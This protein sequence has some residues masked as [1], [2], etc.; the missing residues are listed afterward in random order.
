MPRRFCTPLLAGALLLGACSD[1]TVPDY[2]NPSIE[3]LESNPSRAGVNAA[4]TG[5]LV[6][7]RNNIASP[8]AYVSLLGILGRES[9]NFDP[10]EPRFIT[11]MLAGPMSPSGA[12]GGNIWAVRYRNIRNA[13]VVLGAVEKVPA[14]SEA[15]KEA[16]RGFAKTMQALDFLLVINA[17][18]ANGAP[19]D[20]N[21]PLNELNQNPPKIEPKSAVLQHVAALLDAADTHLQRGGGAFPF[22]ISSGF[23]GFD[24]PTRFRQF[25]RALR[26]R[27]ATYMGAYPQALTA[28]QG[29]FLSTS[30]PLALGAYYTFAPGSGETP[31][32]L[33]A[34][35]IR[36]HPSIRTD[37]ERR[38]DGTAD[39]R[40]VEKTEDVAPR[41]QAGLSSDL[42]F[43]L[44]ASN[45]APVAIIRNEE[46]ILLRAEA[47]WFT[48]DRRGA[49]EDLNLIRQS[50]GGLQAVGEPAT[51]AAF[52]TELL[53]QRRYS[54]LFEGHRWIDLRRFGRLDQLPKDIGTHLIHSKFPI[55]EAECLARQLSG[56]CGAG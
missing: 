20:V 43:K 25:N 42:G 29:S 24:T 10:A 51:D 5:L 18:D 39:R 49:M 6:V 40:L 7:A 23:E 4:A 47:R 34:A 35:T 15:E 50:S 41:S 8:N 37:A 30:A 32:S 19:V 26:A 55:P 3:E 9:Y 27:V 31:N 54:L 21:H 38:A 48:G 44:Y 52:I 33:G 12:F 45:T 16:I 46:L 11:E 36:A 28:L 17:R 2:N 14:F 22:P 56:E 53:R 13:N 1:L